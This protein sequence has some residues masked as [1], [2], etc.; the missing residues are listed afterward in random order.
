M[1]MIQFSVWVGVW[2]TSELFNV[3]GNFRTIHCWFIRHRY[4]D[5]IWITIGSI[6]STFIESAMYRNTDC[7]Y[8]SLTHPSIRPGY[9]SYS[10]FLNKATNDY[11]YYSWLCKCPTKTLEEKN[12]HNEKC[13]VF[14]SAVQCINSTRTHVV[15]KYVSII[16]VPFLLSLVIVVIDS[17]GSYQVSNISRIHHWRR[18]GRL[19]KRLSGKC[20]LNLKSLLL[21]IYVIY[22]H[23]VNKNISSWCTGLQ[24]LYGIYV[25]FICVYVCEPRHGQPLLWRMS[26]I[27][28]NV[29]EVAWLS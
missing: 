11:Y 1:S 17:S 21:R 28:S 3:N 7:Y 4:S 5:I 22:D 26:L 9:V 25:G 19:C 15:C 20:E 8:Y 2:E 12:Q 24:S 23:R 14:S 10:E 18:R 16:T 6:H 27:D 29:S 13:T